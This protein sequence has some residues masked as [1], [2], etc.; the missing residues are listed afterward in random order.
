MTRT[1]LVGRLFVMFAFFCIMRTTFFV[2][3]LLI[4]FEFIRIINFKSFF[5]CVCIS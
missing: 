4:F 1:R 2:L 5:I 3:N